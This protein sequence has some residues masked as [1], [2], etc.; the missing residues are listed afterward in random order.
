M[1]C[2]RRVMQASLIGY[3][4]VMLQLKLYHTEPRII[5]YITLC[6]Y[7]LYFTSALKDYTSLILR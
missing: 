3:Q 5:L 7:F 6:W 2:W 1:R 4:L